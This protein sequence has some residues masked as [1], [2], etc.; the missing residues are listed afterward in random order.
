MSTKH[1]SA[2]HCDGGGEEGGG[3][4]RWAKANTLI[5]Q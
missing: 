3:G 2:I 5:M 1:M 4:K